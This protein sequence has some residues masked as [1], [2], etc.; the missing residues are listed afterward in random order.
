MSLPTFRVLI[1]SAFFLACGSAEELSPSVEAVGGGASSAPPSPS[2]PES[3]AKKLSQA[4]DWNE[5]GIRWLRYD[6]G[7]AEASAGGKPILARVY[8]DWCPHCTEYGKNFFLEEIEALAQDYVMVLVNQ[9]REPA[10][11]QR[12]SPDG[13]YT[14]RTFIL[15]SRGEI[16]EDIIATPSRFRYFYDYRD[17][18]L[19][20]RSMKQGLAPP[21]S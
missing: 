7:L 9:D 15:S 19:L 14:P 20:V 4:L 10:T 5:E 1:L 8:A 18:S 16:R 21:A 3:A 13:T 12:L 2:K 17:P 11:S 6:D